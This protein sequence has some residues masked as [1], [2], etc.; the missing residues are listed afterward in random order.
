MEASGRQASARKA[1]AMAKSLSLLMWWKA[2]GMAFEYVNFI[3]VSNSNALPS[4]KLK[5]GLDVYR[6]KVPPACTCAS[7]YPLCTLIF[8]R[9][10]QRG[11]GVGS[12]GCLAV[13]WLSRSHMA[14]GHVGPAVWQSLALPV[15]SVYRGLGGLW[16]VQV[17]P[18]PVTWSCSGW[19]TMCGG[20]PEAGAV[21][22]RPVCPRWRPC[23]QRLS[24][25]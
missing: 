2:S 14:G 9:G 15:M 4:S 1:C 6:V 17:W 12:Q 20:G 10:P 13:V 19:E 3:Y 16:Q 21:R 5:T 7:A 8:L 11:H 25:W 23:W 24:W 18:L 22:G